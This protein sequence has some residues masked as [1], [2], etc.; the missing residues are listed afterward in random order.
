MR[1]PTG[2]VPPYQVQHHRAAV[3]DAAAPSSAHRRLRQLVAQL[4]WTGRAAA[5]ALSSTN[6]GLRRHETRRVRTTCAA[7]RPAVTAIR[8]EHVQRFIR[9]KRSA[10]AANCD[11]AARCTTKHQR[12]LNDW[13]AKYSAPTAAT[14]K[15][16]RQYVSQS[17]WQRY[18]SRTQ[19]SAQAS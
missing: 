11:A 3:A 13:A 6:F 14:G 18:A 16:V 1:Q 5:A 8:R 9:E 15:L 12:L 4:V 19:P 7:Q 2:P 17:V 10:R